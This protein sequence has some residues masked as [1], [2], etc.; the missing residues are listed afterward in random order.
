MQAQDVVEH[1]KARMDKEVVLRVA[2]SDY[3]IR[4]FSDAGGAVIIEA[5]EAIIPGGA[6][7]PEEAVQEA[8]QITPVA[9][10]VPDQV[11]DKGKER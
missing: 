8:E 7:G 1:L 3:M 4:G 5:G 11:L 9:E 2:G 10:A 6:I